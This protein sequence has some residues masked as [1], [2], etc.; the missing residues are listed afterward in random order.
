MHTKLLTHVA[1]TVSA[2]AI[3]GTFLGW[4]PPLAAF[5]ASLWYMLQI[6]ES[7]T[8]QTWLHKR[9]IVRRYRKR[10]FRRIGGGP[11]PDFTP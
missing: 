6:F 1:D 11:Q 7:H 2:A 9:K 10:R 3:L 4:L 8:V 5:M